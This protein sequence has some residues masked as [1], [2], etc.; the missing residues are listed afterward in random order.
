MCTCAHCAHRFYTLSL[1]DQLSS[2]FSLLTADK[3]TPNIRNLNRMWNEIRDCILSAA[4][5]II[6][7]VKQVDKTKQLLPPSLVSSNADMRYVASIKIKLTGKKIKSNATNINDNN[8]K[9]YYGK[10]K[11][12][13]DKYHFNTQFP[14]SLHSSSF[15]EIKAAITDLYNLISTI[16]AKEK[17]DYQTGM[18]RKFIE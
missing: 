13:T 10:L 3:P 12:I 1:T 11:F 16:N 4:K 9:M 18:I 8:W 5:E 2:K 6:P 15:K 7:K 14:T 17:S